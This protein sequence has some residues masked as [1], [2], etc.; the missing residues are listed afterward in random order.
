[1]DVLY[2][3]ESLGKNRLS[4]I[5][6]FLYNIHFI[7][8]VIDMTID[9][10]DSCKAFLGYKKY[11]DLEPIARLNYNGRE[12]LGQRV[13]VTSKRD[14]ENVC[15]Y[16]DIGNFMVDGEV[17]PQGEI[18]PVIGSRN[19]PEASSDIQ[20]RMKATPEWKKVQDL[21][22]TER[23]DYNDVYVCYGELQKHISPTRVERNKKN[24]HWVMFDVW[25]KKAERYLGYNKVFELGKKYRIPVVKLLEIAECNTMEEVQ[26]MVD[27]WMKWCRRHRREGIV[28]KIYRGDQPYFKE[29]IALPKKIKI[30]K[31]DHDRPLLPPMPEDK[32]LRVLKRTFDEIGA[33]NWNNT[34][35]VMPA[36]AK[37]IAVEAEEHYYERPKNIYAI[38]MTT[39][40]EKLKPEVNTD[41]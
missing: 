10:Y 30:R 37:Y 13:Y 20:N 31:S 24:L 3:R 27:T 16:E 39:D 22:K 21:V 8:T 7:F 12:I 23:E 33:E 14:G 11:R 5:Q 17:N 6:T 36:F 19:Q 38:Y 26:I 28:G 35:I 1:M 15:I 32:I 34:S 2:L 29:R 4:I 40:V 25:D 18:I 41:G 9:V